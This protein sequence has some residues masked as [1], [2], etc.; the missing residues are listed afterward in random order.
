MILED[1]FRPLAGPIGALGISTE[2]GV[3]FGKERRTTTRAPPGEMFIAVANSKESLPDRSF[4]RIKTGMDSCN[5]AHW[6]CSV[7][8]KVSGTGCTHPE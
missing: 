8:D 1:V 3:D 6:R 2:I 4:V 7:L 5:R